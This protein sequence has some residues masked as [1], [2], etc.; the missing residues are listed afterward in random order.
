M[1]LDRLLAGIVLLGTIAVFGVCAP[2]VLHQCEAA[3]AWPLVGLGVFG[4]FTIVRWCDE[5]LS[6]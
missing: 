6:K 3:F 1:K 2:M 5:A 4:L